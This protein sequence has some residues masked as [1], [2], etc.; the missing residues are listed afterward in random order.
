MGERDESKLK[1]EFKERD[2]QRMRNLITKKFGNKTVTQIGYTRITEDHE[3]GDIWEENGK[4][5]IIKD[6]IKQTNTKLDSFKKEI[7][8]PLL[9]PNCGHQMKSTLDKKMYPIHHKCFDCVVKM[10]TEL[11]RIGKYEEYTKRMIHGNMSGFI[12]DAKEFVVEFI[13]EAEESFYTEQGDKE[14]FSG[15]SNK[16]QIAEKWL[17]ELN[18]MEQTIKK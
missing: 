4:E 10:E 1:K 6:G 13:N 7:M 15:S 3:E 12:Q 11:R 9:C 16:K 2:V 18:E 5:W 17:Q 8:L 14:I